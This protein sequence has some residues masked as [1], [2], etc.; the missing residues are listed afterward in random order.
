MNTLTLIQKSNIDNNKKKKPNNAF[1]LK[2]LIITP[3]R[4]GN[5]NLCCSCV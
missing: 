1:T 4:N 2:G 3:I 5:H